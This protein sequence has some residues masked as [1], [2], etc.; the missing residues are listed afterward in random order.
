MFMERSTAGMIKGA[1]ILTTAGA[2]PP[3]GLLL[4]EAEKI[5]QVT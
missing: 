5:T 1:D 2:Y 3:P 4:H